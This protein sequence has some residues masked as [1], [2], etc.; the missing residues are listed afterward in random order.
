MGNELMPRTW[1]AQMLARLRTLVNL[2]REELAARMIGQHL[3]V[4]RWR[5]VD[6]HPSENEA[7]WLVRCIG[8]LEEA[9]LN[10]RWPAAIE[11][12]AFIVCAARCFPGVSDAITRLSMAAAQDEIESYGIVCQILDS[13]DLP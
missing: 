5:D 11:P 8:A 2:S 9:D 3:P 10:S 7:A 6:S 12:D 1:F 13:R 4:A